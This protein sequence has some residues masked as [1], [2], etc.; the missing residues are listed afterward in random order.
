MLTNNRIWKQGLEYVGVETA[1][2]ALSWREFTRVVLLR[3]SE[4]SWDLIKAQPYNG[5]EKCKV[6]VIPVGTRGYSGD[7]YLIGVEECAIQILLSCN[8]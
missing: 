6:D 1:Q 3:G 5:Y 4:V 7:R 2:E 8:V